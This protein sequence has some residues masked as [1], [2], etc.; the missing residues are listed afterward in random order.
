MQDEL[1]GDWRV[2]AV[3]TLAKDLPPA[4]LG[5]PSHKAG[6]PVH[7]L[8]ATRQADGSLV[9]FVTPSPSAM[10]LD[11]A[12]QSV[13][14]ANYLKPAIKFTGVIEPR[15][16]G[17]NVQ[18]NDLPKLYD[19]F[20]SCMSVVTF[21]FQAIEAFSNEYI[22]KLVNEPFPIPRRKGEIVEMSADEIIRELGT[23]EKLD[24]VLPSFLG[25]KS[26]KGNKL[27]HRFVELKRFRD[28]I[29]HPKTSDT[30]PKGKIDRESLFF[31]FFRVNT[32]SYPL[33]SMDVISYYLPSTSGIPRWLLLA[34][35]Q[36][37]NLTA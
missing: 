10:A 25:V 6:T 21:S 16:S 2:Q 19:Y 29:I 5:G 34:R 13:V 4:Y 8:T 17:Y 30:N 37:K 35:E 33:I 9:S 12:M 7:L 3:T 31:K 18:P 32:T 23:Q 1:L 36:F 27:W 15:G 24:L 11:L 28:S 26:P 22:D 20:E 14:R